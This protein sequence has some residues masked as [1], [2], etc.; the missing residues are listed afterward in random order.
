MSKRSRDSD[1][2]LHLVLDK[3]AD[4]DRRVEKVEAC[5]SNHVMSELKRQ[6]TAITIAVIVVPIAT[7]LI[8]AFGEEIGFVLT[9]ILDGIRIVTGL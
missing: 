2:V 9:R 6:K 5:V 3:L 1:E 4:L 7:A 8:Q